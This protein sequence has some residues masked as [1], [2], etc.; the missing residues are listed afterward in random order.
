MRRV[1]SVLVWRQ[2]VTRTLPADWSRLEPVCQISPDTLSHVCQENTGGYTGQER[3]E[4]TQAAAQQGRPVLHGTRGLRGFHA[5]TARHRGGPRD[6]GLAGGF[7]RTRQSCPRPHQVLRQ[8]PESVR[9]RPPHLRDP[10]DLDTA[11]TWSGSRGNSEVASQC[12][13]VKY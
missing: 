4:N 8:P 2:R 13:L 1:Q 3:Q 12:W 10:V 9:G 6:L 11:G 5:D 7:L